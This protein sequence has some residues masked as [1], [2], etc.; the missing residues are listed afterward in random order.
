MSGTGTSYCCPSGRFH[1]IFRQKTVMLPTHGQISVGSIVRIAGPPAGPAPDR[2][3]STGAD[4]LT[5][6]AERG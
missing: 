6:L 4:R 3:T 5:C 1:K 2:Q